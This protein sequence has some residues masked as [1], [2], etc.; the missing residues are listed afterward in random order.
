MRQAN[1]QSQTHSKMLPPPFTNNHFSKSHPIKP[2]PSS[3]PSQ[4]LKPTVSSQKKVRTD[5]KI[6]SRRKERD[7]LG[8]FKAEAK[9][10]SRDPKRF[11]DDFADG[12]FD[13][14]PLTSKNDPLEKMI[15]NISISSTNKFEKKV[16]EFRNKT[17]DS[18]K[19]TFILNVASSPAASQNISSNPINELLK[20]EGINKTSG[21]VL[22]EVMNHYLQEIKLVNVDNIISWIYMNSSNYHDAN[23]QLPYGLPDKLK[24]PSDPQNV[25]D[26]TLSEFIESSQDEFVLLD[27]EYNKKLG[28]IKTKLR[29]NYDGIHSSKWSAED[30]ALL[31]FIASTLKEENTLS[32]SSL[33]NDL[34]VKL[35]KSK[36]REEIVAQKYR[37]KMKKF[38]EER[39]NN[40][41]RDWVRDKVEMQDKI[42]F[43]WDELH[44]KRVTKLEFNAKAKKQRELCFQWASI[45]EKMRKDKCAK[46]HRLE[47]IVEPFEKRLEEQ[48]RYKRLQEIRRRDEMKI[49][50]NKFKTQKMEQKEENKKSEAIIQDMIQFQ[51]KL[52]ESYNRTRVDFRKYRQEEKLQTRKELEAMKEYEQMKKE[53]LLEKTKEKVEID[54][55]PENVLQDTFSTLVRRNDIQMGKGSEEESI[56]RFFRER[57]SFSSETVWADRR[58]RVEAKLRDAGLIDS[59]YARQVLLAMNPK[60]KRHLSSQIA[61]DEEPSPTA[62]IV[63]PL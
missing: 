61:F 36:T 39:Y 10:I 58:V 12:K 8:K 44:K 59:P 19:R 54:Y 14:C 21:Q 32:A 2:A 11:L 62:T 37:L 43:A 29:D 27:A 56:V 7:Y 50:V 46:I 57:Y 26:K 6:I 3:S 28:E 17:I 63:L 52:S 16:T 24:I 51:N 53:E 4:F 35:F 40:I 22:D 49:E 34:T 15:E 41:I 1:F 60:P 47:I 25:E 55:D 30:S 20:L 48:D 23:F 31:F 9:N 33:L 42:N 13:F 5:T 18:K 38:W 45:V